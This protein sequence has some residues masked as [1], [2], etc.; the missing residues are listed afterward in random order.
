MVTR[1]KT[2]QEI[3]AMRNSGQMLASVL[4]TLE[5]KL[6]VGM[7]TKDLA[8]IATNE[9][10]SLGGDAAFL[11]YQ[12]FPD[13]ICISVNEEV[14]H[15]IP[16]PDKIIGEGDI[17]GLDFGVRYQGMITDAAISVIAG[18][19]KQIG[20]IRLVEDT[21]QAL[22]AGIA[23]VHDQVRTGDIGSAIENSL[24]H[25]TYGIV[26]DLVGHGVGHHVHED[27]NIPNYGRPNTGPW[28]SAGMTIAIEPMVTLGTDRVK[29]AQDG[30]T[31]LTVDGSRSAHFEHTVLITED[32]AEIL[33]KL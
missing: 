4:K 23:T 5:K 24:R 7:S 20:H 1:V 22:Q 16:R 13:V 8:I 9:L 3:K 27:P 12:D 26:R 17:V 29:V 6:V 25:R 21:A 18:R 31:I 19:P 2:A 14:V 10:K 15:G 11:G 30:W 32:G 28:L 33:T